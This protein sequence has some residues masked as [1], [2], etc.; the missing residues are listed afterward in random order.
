MK[1]EFDNSKLEREASLYQN[2]IPQG[3]S[4]ISLS[5]NLFGIQ[6]HFYYKGWKYMFD[7]TPLD[8]ND[9]GENEICCFS[10]DNDGCR[11][12]RKIYNATGKNI[13]RSV[14]GLFLHFNKVIDA[15]NCNLSN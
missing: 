9:S 8:S 3:V 5:H 12:H 4:Q 6:C 11:N 15:I 13:E 1:I 10:Y 2:L 14:K 7:V